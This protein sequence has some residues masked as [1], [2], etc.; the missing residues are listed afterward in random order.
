M[1]SKEHQRLAQQRLADC[2]S[3]AEGFF[4]RQFNSPALL[5]NQ[6]G[7]IAGTAHLQKNLIKLNAVLMA[8]NLDQFCQAVIPHEVAHILVFQLYGRVKPHGKEWQGIMTGVFGLEPKVRH[9]M[10]VTKTQ[11]KTFDYHCRCGTM[12]LSIRRH[13]KI[14]RKQQ[15]YLCRQCNHVLH[16]VENNN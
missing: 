8:D 14:V 16:Q 13:N 3:A 5:F 15:T 7:K 11:G 10:D 1:L 6:R 9:Q 4:G 12:K 2:I